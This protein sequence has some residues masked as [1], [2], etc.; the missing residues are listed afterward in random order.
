MVQNVAA[1]AQI[2]D[3]CSVRPN[4]QVFPVAFFSLIWSWNIYYYCLSFT[5][6]T[7]QTTNY[8]ASIAAHMHLQPC[9]REKSITQ[10]AL[11]DVLIA[12]WCCEMM[13]STDVWFSIFHANRRAWLCQLPREDSFLTY[14]TCLT[15]PDCLFESSHCLSHPGGRQILI[16]L[17]R[18]FPHF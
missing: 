9:Q 14:S 10:E 1:A 11:L 4:L 8:I 6:Q 18:E 2:L 13:I 5:S 3:S 17:S 12:W 16:S 7:R 15:R